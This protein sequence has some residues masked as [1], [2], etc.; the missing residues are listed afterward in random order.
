MQCI[1]ASTIYDGIF[2]LW[3][4]LVR[5]RSRNFS[6]PQSSTTASEKVDMSS[7]F[8]EYIDHYWYYVF[9]SG[10][11]FL[12]YEIQ[13]SMNFV[14]TLIPRTSSC[15]RQGEKQCRTYEIKCFPTNKDFFDPVTLKSIY[16][17]KC[18]RM[19][20]RVSNWQYLQSELEI[21]LFLLCLIDPW[22]QKQPLDRFEIP[23]RSLVV[24]I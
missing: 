21:I 17:G 13:E 7:R 9:W 4:N 20:W 15:K 11:F 16:G 22:H 3:E 2:F 19:N 14:R 23:H 5:I 10:F 8:P 12:S 1:Y 6:M 24:N 18:K